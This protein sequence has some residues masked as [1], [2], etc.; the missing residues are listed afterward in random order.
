MRQGKNWRNSVDA[1]QR[2]PC[3]CVDSWIIVDVW[4]ETI[5]FFPSYDNN[6]FIFTEDTSIAV[7]C[8]P[9]QFLLIHSSECFFQENL[10][11]RICNMHTVKISTETSNQNEFFPYSYFYISAKSINKNN[12][13]CLWRPWHFTLDIIDFFPVVY[14]SQHRKQVWLIENIIS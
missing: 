11:L 7:E 4:H 1:T 9:F 5:T 8:L 10:R 2:R 3:L 14:L 13:C 6:H 12:V